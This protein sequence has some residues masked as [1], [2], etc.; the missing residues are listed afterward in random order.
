VTPQL[1]DGAVRPAA[2][3]AG[4]RLGVP[5]APCAAVPGRLP[6]A[7]ALAC[8]SDC[9][10]K[11]RCPR[12]PN[13]L[14]Q[15][16][17]FAVRPASG[18]PTAER[19]HPLAAVTRRP[20]VR[21]RGGPRTRKRMRRPASAWRNVVA[22]AGRGHVHPPDCSPSCGTSR[23]AP[24]H[25]RTS[26]PPH[27]PRWRCATVPASAVVVE[28]QAPCDHERHGPA[29]LTGVG[30]QTSG[31]QRSLHAVARAHPRCPVGLQVFVAGSRM[32]TNAPFSA[33]LLVCLR[34]SLHCDPSDS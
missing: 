9:G 24:R 4:R 12:S 17:Q 8:R 21:P 28:A 6:P 19:A 16:H 5:G 18:P 31:R 23:C 3:G 29:P 22:G 2:S 34:S 1:C 26:W 20:T 15:Y 14:F 25:R 10:T 30:A 11:L 33:E 32:E 7:H 27:V 13:A